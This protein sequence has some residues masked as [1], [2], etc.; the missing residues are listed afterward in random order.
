MLLPARYLTFYSSRRGAERLHWPKLWAEYNHN[1]RWL[2]QILKC[3]V[4]NWTEI[5]A[6]NRH[7]HNT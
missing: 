7:T 4:L 5:N 2:L 6:I 1:N 3:Y